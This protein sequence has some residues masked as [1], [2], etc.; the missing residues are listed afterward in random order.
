MKKGLWS[1][2][3]VVLKAVGVGDYRMLEINELLGIITFYFDE[4][5]L[6][7]FKLFFNYISRR[8]GAS[9]PLKIYSP[10]LKIFYSQ[11]VPE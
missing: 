2:C 8:L 4:N 1:N 11:T 3:D 5:L 7:N 9:T 6:P 10:A